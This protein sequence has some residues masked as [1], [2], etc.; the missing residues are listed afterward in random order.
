MRVMLRLP[1]ILIL[2]H[3]GRGNMSGINVNLAL[4]HFARGGF[5]LPVLGGLTPKGE[6]VFSLIS[7]E[8]LP[9]A[10]ISGSTMESRTRNH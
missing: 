3:K 9:S 6:G 7:Q 10:K 4:P 8:G 2:S 5:T 1:L